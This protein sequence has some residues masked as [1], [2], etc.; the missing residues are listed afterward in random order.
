MSPYIPQFW[1]LDKLR[2]YGINKAIV[3]F[4]R[5]NT[6]IKRWFKIDYSEYKTQNIG[7]KVGNA[8][9][10]HLPLKKK[11]EYLKP[12][13]EI[14]KEVSVCEDNDT[15]YNYWKNNINP[16]KNDCCNLRL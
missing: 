13:L 16:N 3:E 4:L 12:L 7:Y 14:F 11:V 9:Y 5:V 15:A 2:T 8:G 6:W 1:D 10:R